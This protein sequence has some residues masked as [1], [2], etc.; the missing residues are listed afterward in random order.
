MKIFHLDELLT[1]A[2]C[3]M[4]WR[5]RHE[6]GLPYY[7]FE[8]YT[9]TYQ[10]VRNL[11]CQYA[12]LIADHARSPELIIK[13]KARYEVQRTLYE[14][15]FSHST[16]S[17]IYDTSILAMKGFEHELLNRD[18]DWKFAYA[19]VPAGTMINGVKI[20]GNFDIYALRETRRD[21]YHS[22]V[23]HISDE[24]SR[25]HRARFMPLRY[26]WHQAVL[27]RLE[28]VKRGSVVHWVFSPWDP[29]PLVPEPK[30][31]NLGELNGTVR[32]VTRGIKNRAVWQ[33]PPIEECRLCCYHKIC[34]ARHTKNKISDEEKQELKE[35]VNWTIEKRRA[36]HDISVP[37]AE[38]MPE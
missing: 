12:N 15:G 27:N 22:L 37:C 4:K 26:A 7:E 13:R 38:K 33:A 16:A 11:A 1:Y 36:K 23:I 6:W 28:S 25:Y 31:F 2:H 8:P 29:G 32:G 18:H 30:A 3:P 20:I 14:G 34:T 17:Q 19:D 5:Y 35:R 24:Y 10:L 21:T 9:A